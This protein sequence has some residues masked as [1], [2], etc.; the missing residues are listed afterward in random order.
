MR[1]K[2]TILFWSTYFDLEKSRTQGRRVPK[3]LAVLS[4]KLDELQRAA[5]RLGLN[6]KV[7]SDTAHPCSPWKRTGLLIIPKTEAKGIILKK[8]AKELYKLRA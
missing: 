8:I 4:P 6:P 7:V 5:K 1:K 3:N 2:N